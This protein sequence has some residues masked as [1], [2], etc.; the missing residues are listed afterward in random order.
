MPAPPRSGV[1]RPVLPPR[2]SIQAVADSIGDEPES[3]ADLAGGR[4]DPD[5]LALQIDNDLDARVWMGTRAHDRVMRAG[6]LVGR[7]LYDEIEKSL[8]QQESY[9]EFETRLLKRLGVGPNEETIGNA[10]L[11]ALD[12]TLDNEV[13]LAWNEGILAAVGDEAMVAVWRAELDDATTP[14]CWDNHGRLMEELDETPPRHPRC[15]CSPYSIPDPN[16][17]DPDWARL[18]R[19]ILEEMAEERDSGGALMEADRVPQEAGLA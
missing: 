13:R 6:A 15:R 10:A 4:A 3:L 18:G 1:R 8:Y 14:G 17:P 19:E 5:F 2:P 7:S 16:S 9:D 11:R 12:A